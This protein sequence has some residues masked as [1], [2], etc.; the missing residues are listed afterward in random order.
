MGRQADINATVVGDLLLT[1]DDL[2]AIAAVLARV[3]V[4]GDRY[5]AHLQARVGAEGVV[6]PARVAR[7]SATR[8][9]RCC[10]FHASGRFLHPAA[11]LKSPN[12]K[13]V[14]PGGAFRTSF[15]LFIRRSSVLM[16]IAKG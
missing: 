9:G 10:R 7:V 3:T 13:R 4:Q 14:F 8:D 15:R 11:Q 16:V 6:M 12:V 2:G 1:P 5:P